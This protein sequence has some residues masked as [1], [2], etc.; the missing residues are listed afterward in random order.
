[1]D[2]VLLPYKVANRIFG[3]EVADNYAVV[4]ITISNHN[5]S[6]GL[7]IHSALLDYSH[8]LFSGRFSSIAGDG[9]VNTTTYQQQ[10]KASQVSSAEARIVRGESLDKQPWT[11]RNIMVH[12]ATIVGTLATGFQF[13]T[14]DTNYL[15]CIAS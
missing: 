8:W 5:P 6:A 9:T 15:F 1:M 10:N 14:T 4:Q 13:L 2:S 12:T 3:G 11:A 7:I